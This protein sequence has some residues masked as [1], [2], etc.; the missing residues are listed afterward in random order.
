MY[1]PDAPLP[2]ADSLGVLLLVLPTR[3]IGLSYD[4]C[5]NLSVLLH[6]T[7]LKS[8]PI[9]AP[10]AVIVHHVQSGRFQAFLCLR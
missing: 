10:T 5:K 7:R 2:Q 9:S 3:T 4:F 8:D 1:L 6:L